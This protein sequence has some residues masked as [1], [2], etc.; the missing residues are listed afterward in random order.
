MTWKRLLVLVVTTGALAFA[1]GQPLGGEPRLSIRLWVALTAAWLLG[2]LVTR[3]LGHLPVAGGASMLPS[4]RRFWPRRRRLTPSGTAA[5]LRAAAGLVKRAGENPRTHH[6]QLRPRLLA[7]ADHA[8]PRRATDPHER[9]RELIA[10][11]GDAGWLIDPAVSDRT[12]TTDDID[13]FLDRIHIADR[14]ATAAPH[15]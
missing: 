15:P 9:T 5:G 1:I 4:L 13:R 10:A 8:T 3:L 14:P 12:P 6:N 2:V 7:L 11:A